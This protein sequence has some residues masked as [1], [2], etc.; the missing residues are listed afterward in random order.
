[1]D[2]NPWSNNTFDDYQKVL[3]EFGITPFQWEKLPDPSKLFRR[4]IVFGQRGF[5]LILGAIRNNK[6]FAILT[7]LAPSGKMHIGHKMVIDQVLYFQSLGAKVTLAVADIEAYGVRGT[8]LLDGR[9]IAIEEY[10]LNYIALGLKA[11]GCEIYFQSRREAVKDLAYSLGAR[12]NLSEMSAIYGFKGDTNMCHIFAPLVQ[13]GDIL[14]PQL[15]EFHGPIPTLVPVGVD[16][17]PHIRLTRKL[18]QAHRLVNVK[19]TKDGKIGV[20]VKTEENVGPLLDRCQNALE[21]IGFSMFKKIK[22]YKALYVNDASTWDL[23]RI[24]EAVIPIEKEM[25]GYAFYP[26]ASTYHRFMTG[27]TGGKMS[28]SVP[29]SS[30]FLSD[31]PEE[32]SRKVARAMTGGRQSLREQ[33]EEGGDPNKCSIYELFLYHLLDDD[34]ELLTIWNRCKGGELMCGECKK[35]AG[36]LI[37]TFLRELAAKRVGAQERLGEYLRED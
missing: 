3:D 11:Q 30:I 9:T 8:S 15:D 26:P 23:D 32:G 5:E 1:M 29:D 33:K 27:L 31:T 18:A 2:I 37:K 34:E 28:S 12:T 7:G 35:R 22:R 4:G 10:L 17:D 36:E 20:F 21:R 19:E 24:D 25:G 13:V 6:P 14:H 16:Q